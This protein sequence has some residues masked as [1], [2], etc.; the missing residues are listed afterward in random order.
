MMD[1]IQ[2]WIQAFLIKD[3]K[4]HRNQVQH[5]LLRFNEKKSPACH[6]TE[7]AVENFIPF[8]MVSSI[9]NLHD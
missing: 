7:Q 4:N 3:D 5:N 9:V 2:L 8:Y 6:F 1:R